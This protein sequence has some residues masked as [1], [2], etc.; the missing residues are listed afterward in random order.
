LPFKFNL[1]R[2]NPETYGKEA[3][4]DGQ[5]VWDKGPMPQYCLARQTML[6]QAGL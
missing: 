2:Y 3:M 1:Q 4:L 5:R 6:D